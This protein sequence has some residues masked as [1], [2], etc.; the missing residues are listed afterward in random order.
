MYLSINVFN[1]YQRLTGPLSLRRNIS[2]NKSVEGFES[3]NADQR[4][5]IEVLDSDKALT[6]VLFSCYFVHQKDPQTGVVRRAAD[7]EYIAPWYRSVEKLG[8][9]GIIIHDGLEEAFISQ[10]QTER[11]SFRRYTPGD[12]SIFEERWIAYYL[13][14]S[15]SNIQKAFFAD[16]N[17]VYITKAPFELIDNDLTLYVGR[18]NANK[19]KN[20]EWMLAELADYERASDTTAPLLYRYQYVY[21]AGVIGGSRQVMLFLI[22]RVVDSIVKTKANSH[23]DMT[24][25]NLCIHKYFF[26]HIDINLLSSRFTTPEDDQRASHRYLVTGYPFNSN[27]KAFDLGSDAYFIHK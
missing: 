9:T 16:I 13:F 26:P 12:Y 8:I 22:S 27:F 10:Y 17:D 2:N 15:Q 18:D 4:R 25:L 11:I 7:I 20:S 14:L 24:I 6:E 21:N 23:M 19:I 5:Q 1:L 3:V